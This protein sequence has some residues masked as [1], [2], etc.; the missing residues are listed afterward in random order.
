MAGDLTE[1]QATRIAA[2]EV[3]VLRA[4]GR[5]WPIGSIAG[6]DLMSCSAGAGRRHARD[7]APFVHR[8]DDL[9]AASDQVVHRAAAPAR[10]ARASARSSARC[11][12]RAG[13]GRRIGA[14]HAEQDITGDAARRPRRAAATPRRGH[15]APIPQ[16]RSI[17]WR[18]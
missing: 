7:P 18:A 12:N 15:V 4:T 17:T 3:D 13:S 16:K 14:P 2:V 9:R 5:G 1:G 10:S 6:R 11:T 8:A